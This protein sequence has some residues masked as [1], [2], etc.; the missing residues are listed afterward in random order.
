MML[1]MLVSQGLLHTDQESAANRESHVLG[2]NAERE[3][4]S[5]RNST[6]SHDRNDPSSH[7]NLLCPWHKSPRGNRSSCVCLHLINDR[8]LYYALVLGCQH[9]CVFVLAC[10]FF[11]QLIWACM[12]D[13]LLRT[14]DGIE[15]WPGTIPVLFD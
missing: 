13:I 9:R 7:L 5:L 11:W 3:I 4:R 10:I 14:A 8:E 15:S 1:F 2:G 12:V 6:Q